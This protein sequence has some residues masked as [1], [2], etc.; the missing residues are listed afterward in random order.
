MSA[1]WSIGPHEADADGVV[2]HQRHAGV[3]GDLRNRLEVGHVQLRVADGLGINRAGLRRD[4]LPERLR[5][6]RVDELHRAAQ[7]GKRVVE[8]LVRPAV[9]VVGRDD[10]V[11]HL[12]DGQQRQRGRRLPDETASAPVP[13]SIAAMRCSNTSVVGFMIRV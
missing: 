11:A 7:L 9:E 4:G 6:A 1:P 8:E 3:M 10:L 5:L 13:P 12:R 2:H